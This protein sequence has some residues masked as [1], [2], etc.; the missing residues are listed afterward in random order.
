MFIAV[1][2]VIREENTCLLDRTLVQVQIAFDN[3]A[4]GV[5]LI[6]AD[7]EISTQDILECYHY[8]R[9]VYSDNFIGINFMVDPIKSAELIP[10]GASMLWFDKGIGTRT[11]IDVLD[12][13]SDIL[14]KRNWV[15]KVFGGFYFKGNNSVIPERETIFE[16]AEIASSYLDVL[17][18]SGSCTGVPIELE[19]LKTISQTNKVIAL[20]SGV[21]IENIDLFLPYSTYFLIGTGIEMSSQNQQEIEFYKSAG[22]PEAV[23]VGNLDPNKIRKIANKI[24]K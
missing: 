6:P 16:Q 15:G 1:I 21:N 12:R 8:V 20:A 23:S 24:K 19:T 9:S 4:D 2:H 5:A 17:V 13:V 3:S 11:N 18:T 22:L 7:A 10:Y 14:K